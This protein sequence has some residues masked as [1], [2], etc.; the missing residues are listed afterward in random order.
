MLEPIQ[1]VGTALQAQCPRDVRKVLLYAEIE[2]GVVAA[3]VFF[4]TATNGLQFRYASDELE[5]LTYEFWEVGSGSILPKSWRA[6]EY[7]LVG[8]KLTVDLTYREEF[9]ANEGEHE[10]R[11][12]VIAR[13]FPGL[14]P[15]F[16]N[17]D[18]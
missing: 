6:I 7:A 1:L 18:G 5:R 17:P 4:E 3:S 13:Q 16:S 11:P 10:R 14:N 12:K 2:E 8:Q 9:K 15:N